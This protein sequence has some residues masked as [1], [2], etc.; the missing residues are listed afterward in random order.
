MS[1]TSMLKSRK[2]ILPPYF[3]CP[4]TD[5][6][7]PRQSETGVSMSL[8]TRHIF[9]VQR[10]ASAIKGYSRSPADY[11]TQGNQGSSQQRNRGQLTSESG[12]TA[13]DSRKFLPPNQYLC[14]ERTS[15]Q[16]LPRAPNIHEHLRVMGTR[17]QNYFPSNDCRNW[18]PSIFGYLP[19]RRAG[20]C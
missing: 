14:S 5:I 15:P 19:A 3:P 4:W 20:R 6:V 1:F 10:C 8:C 2:G 7:L 11:C 12:E 17:E 16:E 9:W 13:L 18:V